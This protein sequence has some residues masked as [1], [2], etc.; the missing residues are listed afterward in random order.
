MCICIELFYSFLLKIIFTVF[1]LIKCSWVDL[2]L[3][4]IRRNFILILLKVLFCLLDIKRAIHYFDFYFQARLLLFEITQ[5]QTPLCS[6]IEMTNGIT[7]FVEVVGYRCYC[8]YESWLASC[9]VPK[10]DLFF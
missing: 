9:D 2:L 10:F 8:P 4:K 6:F 5:S 7:L 3:F 1:D